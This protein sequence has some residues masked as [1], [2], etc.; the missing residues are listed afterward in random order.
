MK[1]KIVLSSLGIVFLLAAC[2]QS[3]VNNQDNDLDEST[4][5]AQILEVHEKYLMVTPNDG[6]AELSSADQISVSTIEASLMDKEGN[7]ISMNDFEEG[8][9]VE[10]MYDGMLA[11]SY[12][13][14]I[15][16]CYEIRMVE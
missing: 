16:N 5:E 7:T 9:Q 3:Q 4:F 14:Q 1:L 15:L 11:E 2:T 13:A 10:I 6:E 8:M 12:P